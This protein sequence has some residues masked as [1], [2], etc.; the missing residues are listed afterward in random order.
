MLYYDII[1]IVVKLS[2]F[3]LFLVFHLCFRFKV[4][5]ELTLASISISNY[6]SYG[7]CSIV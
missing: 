1:I 2:F 7:N 5:I 3:V 6:K 4:K